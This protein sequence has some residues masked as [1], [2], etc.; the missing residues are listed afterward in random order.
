MFLL[1]D[2]DGQPHCG[3]QLILDF[4]IIMKV[5]LL[6]SGTLLITIEF[7]NNYSFIQTLRKYS[8]SYFTAQF[9]NAAR[10]CSTQARHGITNPFQGDILSSSLE[11]IH[12][13]TCDGSDPSRVISLKLIDFT[14]RD[15]PWVRLGGCDNSS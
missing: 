6:I 10:L 1:T 3:V 2:N 14:G 15:G 5:K 12:P 4:G 13:I 11:I 9:N 7:I 8:R